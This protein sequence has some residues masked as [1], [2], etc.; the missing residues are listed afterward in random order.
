MP[1]EVLAAEV[2]VVAPEVDDR[3]LAAAPGT[4]RARL[5][6]M[7]G[8]ISTSSS[9]SSMRVAGHERVAADDEHRLAVELEAVEQRDRP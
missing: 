7:T 6:E 8:R 3:R 5:P 1:Q 4:S 2:G 9:S